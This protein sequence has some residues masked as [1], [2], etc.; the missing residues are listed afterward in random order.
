MPMSQYEYVVPRGADLSDDE[1][2]LVESWQARSID[3][4]WGDPAR[5]WVP[6]VGDCA[7]TSYDLDAL[8]RACE[9]LARSR[10]EHGTAFD[11]ALADLDALWNELAAIDAPPD[12]VR[13][14][15]VAWSATNALHF[16]P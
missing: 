10:A 7:R 12:F 16:G 3:G 6:A 1:R 9:R 13:V 4:G 14:F 5:W 15:S 8:L 11:E 2:R